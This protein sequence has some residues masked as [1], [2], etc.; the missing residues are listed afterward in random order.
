MTVY[1]SK[2]AFQSLG[3]E[4]IKLSSTNL[5]QDCSICQQP[6]AMHPNHTSPR[7]LQRG[8]HPTVHINACGHTHGALCLSAWLDVGN[9]CPTCARILFKTIS[10][11]IAQQDIND[12]VHTLGPEYGEAR[13]MV[14]VVGVMQTR[15]RER[16]A[17]RRIHEFEVDAQKRRDREARDREFALGDEDFLDSEE[18]D[19]G[20]GEDGEDGDGDFEVSDGSEIS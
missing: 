9:S 14:S 11:A 10:D 1:A 20:D 4:T 7:S 6:L 12:I 8:Y 16:E 17:L 18:E 3:L 2:A 13:V 19:F 15:E 5:T